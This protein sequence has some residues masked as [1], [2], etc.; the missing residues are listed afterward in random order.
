MRGSA[1][2][3]ARSAPIASAAWP[4]MRSARGEH[5]RHGFLIGRTLTGFTRKLALGVREP[6]GQ[7]LTLQPK[8]EGVL[9]RRS[10]RLEENDHEILAVTAPGPT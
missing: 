2:L 9:A 10:A 7:R 3:P 1:A 6:R 8:G 5:D 4:R